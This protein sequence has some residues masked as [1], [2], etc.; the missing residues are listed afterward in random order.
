MATRIDN[1]TSEMKLNVNENVALISENG[2]SCILGCSELNIEGET[3]KVYGTMSNEA[4]AVEACILFEGGEGDL[5]REVLYPQLCASF[6]IGEGEG[7]KYWQICG[8]FDDNTTIGDVV[9]IYN[10]YPSGYWN[11]GA[12][13]ISSPAELAAAERRREEER[14]RI[15]A[16]LKEMGFAYSPLYTSDSWY[17]G[18][19]EYHHSHSSGFKF[20]KPVKRSKFPFKVGI[21]LEVIANSREDFDKICSLKS[22]WFFMERD[23]SLDDNGVEIITVP[24]RFEDASDPCFWKPFTAWLSKYAK[25]WTKSCCGLHI[26]LGN[27]VFKV[28]DMD[29]EELKAKLAYTYNYCIDNDP[30]NRTIFGRSSGYSAS[31][32]KTKV[33]DAIET[34]GSLATGIKS[35]LS[36]N[37]VKDALVKDTQNKMRNDRYYEI[38]F[39]GSK[40][41]EFRKGRGSINCERIAG[42]VMY[43]Y[44]M[45]Q[46]TKDAAWGDVLDIDAFLT[47]LRE[48]APEGHPINKW[49][50]EDEADN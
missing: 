47:Y 12:W 6:G 34:I 37:D 7:Y 14:K 19:K 16:E 4:E 42:I 44:L 20:N 36:N 13:T 8:E 10:E 32:C 49:L 43:C 29:A 30:I 23:G 27:E 3:V 25:S 38:N 21:E 9:K 33:G 46:W 22:N 17:Q 35:L 26:H 31:K 28:K 50:C 48:N 15:E 45:T 5:T 39:S 41:T 40:T 1:A 11:T 24:L 18:R 2:Q